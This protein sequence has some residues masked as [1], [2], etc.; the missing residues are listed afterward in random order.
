MRM[1]LQKRKT[2]NTPVFSRSFWRK[3]CI[4][5]PVFSNNWRSVTDCRSNLFERW[6]LTVN[7]MRLLCR[8]RAKQHPFGCCFVLSKPTKVDTMKWLPEGVPFCFVLLC[9]PGGRDSTAANSFLNLE[10]YCSTGTR[11]MTQETQTYD[12]RVMSAYLY[13]MSLW[14]YD[15]SWK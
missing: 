7:A 13:E 9:K 12:P 11:I 6:Y 4:F 2:V 3:R 8:G 14:L 10:W 15:G 5:F 1:E